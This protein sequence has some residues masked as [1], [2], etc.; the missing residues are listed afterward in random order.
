MDIKDIWKGIKE[1]EPV[2]MPACVKDSCSKHP[3]AKL[4]HNLLINMIWA[5]II[6]IGYIAILILFPKW[7]I[8]LAISIVLV[9][10]LWAMGT[11]WQLY[12]QID[13]NVSD[14]DSLLVE[15]K[16]QHRQIKHWMSTQARVALFIYPISAAGGFL[17]GGVV[18]SGKEVAEMMGNMKMW[19]ALAIAI[20]ILTPA[21]HFLARWMNKVAFGNELNRLEDNIRHLENGKE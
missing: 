17:L 2:D 21:A 13:T 8:Q 16:R 5:L 10:S 14:S 7:Q 1:E 12:T 4:K 3:L 15:M 9:F 11:A 20:A 18:G 19:I 6:C